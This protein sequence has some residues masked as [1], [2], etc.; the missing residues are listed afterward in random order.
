MVTKFWVDG[1]STSCVDCQ[2]LRDEIDAEIDDEIDVEINPKHA[3]PYA[4]FKTLINH[5]L[6]RWIAVIPGA[7]LAVL[8]AMLLLNLVLLFFELWPTSKSFINLFGFSN[9]EAVVTDFLIPLLSISVAARIAPKYKLAIAVSFTLV[10]VLIYG[11]GWLDLLTR[12]NSYS[13]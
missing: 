8:A 4:G 7:V 3:P 11:L 2:E 1:S 5:P 12:R 13:Q 6:C 10:N 9:I